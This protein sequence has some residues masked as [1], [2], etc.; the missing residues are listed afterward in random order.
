MAQ[1]SVK[2]F[3]LSTVASAA[4]TGVYAALN[5]TGFIQSP[6]LFRIINAGST[7]IT[8]SYNGVDDHELV[9]ANTIFQLETQTNAQPNGNVA[10]F[11]KKTIV[12][13]KGTAGTGTIY[14]SGYY[15]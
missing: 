3:V 4:L 13:I 12:Y 11:P 2:P 1:N 6:F 9:P 5:G 15:V 14:L 10:L 8:V 7:A